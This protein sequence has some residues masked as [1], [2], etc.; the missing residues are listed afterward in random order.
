MCV[1]ARK[2]DQDYALSGPIMW[3]TVRDM[4][5]EDQLL[6]W[7]WRQGVTVCVNRH[8][9]LCETTEPTVT[10]LGESVLDE[11]HYIGCLSIPSLQLISSLLAV[12]R[13][14][15]K[16]HERNFSKACQPWLASVLRSANISVLVSKLVLRDDL[17]EWT[18]WDS[19]SWRNSRSTSSAAFPRCCGVQTLVS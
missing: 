6:S 7:S 12:Y 2:W 1:S 18:A 10:M 8:G 4:S 16:Q 13:M 17:L 19:R 5:V 3:I 14:S 11:E 15:F 9:S